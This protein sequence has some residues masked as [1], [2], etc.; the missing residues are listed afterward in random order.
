MLKIDREQQTLT[1]LQKP[2]LAEEQ[3]MERADLQEYIYNSSEDFFA[4]IGGRVFVIGKEISPS[5]TVADRIDLLGVD[6]E[7]AVVIVELKRGSNK[8]QMLQAISYA[9]MIARWSPE[10]F[11]QHLSNES[12]EELLD[13]LDV[14]VEDINRRQRILLIAEGYDFALLAGAEWLSEQYGVDIRCS[15]LTLATDPN[16]GAEYLACSNIFPPPELAQQSIARGGAARGGEPVRWNTWDEAVS[17]LENEALKKFVEKELEKGTERYLRRRG[18]HY[19]VDG[20]RRWSIESRNKH[21]YVWQR[22]RFQDDGAF[23]REKISDPAS[24]SAVK[25]GRAL[26]FR[27]HTEEDF[28]TFRRAIDEASTRNGWHDPNF[29]EE[30]A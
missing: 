1:R 8:L 19:R 21:A 3:I 26:S 22:G 30:G 12:W 17:E 7:G 14:D 25:D 29:Q 9:G 20:E 11:Q 16:S 15:S 10:N 28:S 24:V 23:W 2:S 18:F 6:P 27:L 4:E 5:T 13:F